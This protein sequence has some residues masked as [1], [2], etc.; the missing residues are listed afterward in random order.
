MHH[1]LYAGY[2]DF[3]AGG[4]LGEEVWSHS[5]EHADVPRQN[6]KSELHTTATLSTGPFQL[7]WFPR[8]LR[9]R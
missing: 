7:Y 8:L 4:G 2:F 9:E 6:F 5:D 3:A 1:S